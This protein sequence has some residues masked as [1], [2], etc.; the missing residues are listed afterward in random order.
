MGRAL[1]TMW[2]RESGN[3]ARAQTKWVRESG[4]GARAQTDDSAYHSSHAMHVIA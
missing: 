4:N 3:G 2:V 1:R